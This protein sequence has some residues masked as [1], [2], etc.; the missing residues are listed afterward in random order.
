[1]RRSCWSSFT[2][3]SWS[4]F[5]LHL[6][7]FLLQFSLQRIFFSLESLSRNF[8]ETI[9][10]RCRRRRRRRRIRRN[11]LVFAFYKSPFHCQNYL[12]GVNLWVPLSRFI[13]FS[14]DSWF[15]HSWWVRVKSLWWLTVNV[16]WL[17]GKKLEA[18]ILTQLLEN[19]EKTF[20]ESWMDGHSLTQ[21]IFFI[22]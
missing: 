7:F 9:S 8:S 16:C 5:F 6:I 2:S 22:K 15:S 14:L 12:V 13:R 20:R 18:V 11:S 10:L 3:L 21:L 19:L 17:I 1:M 4:N